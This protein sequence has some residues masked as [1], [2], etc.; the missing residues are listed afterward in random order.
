[1]KIRLP[2]SGIFAVILGDVVNCDNNPSRIASDPV[3]YMPVGWVRPCT[4]L[5]G[6][7]IF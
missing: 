4:S 7:G 5:I 2:I 3:K 1:M 6:V